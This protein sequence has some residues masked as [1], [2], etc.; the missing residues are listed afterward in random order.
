[1]TGQN[2]M[3]LGGAFPL[4]QLETNSEQ[5]SIPSEPGLSAEN[6]SERSVVFVTRHEANPCPALRSQAGVAGAPACHASVRLE[7]RVR[8]EGRRKL[9][10]A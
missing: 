7:R 1:M 9:S 2:A 10:R 6:F 4:T 3:G 5:Q 8:L